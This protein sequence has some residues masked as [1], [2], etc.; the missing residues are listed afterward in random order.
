MQK[1]GVTKFRNFSSKNSAISELLEK[2]EFPEIGISGI[3]ITTS[4][5]LSGDPRCNLWK[6][7]I[8][9]CT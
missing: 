7:S 1:M 5:F 3:A 8:Y 2:T 9:R 6:F 4:L